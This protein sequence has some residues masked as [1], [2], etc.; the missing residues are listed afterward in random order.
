MPKISPSNKT[1]CELRGL[2]LFHAGWSNCSMRVRMTLEE[3]GLSWTSHHLN[4]RV[5]EHITPAYFGIHPNGLVPTLIDDGDVW[6]ESADIIRYLDETYPGPRLVPDD[7]AGAEMLL[8]WTRLASD[9]HVT[10][11]KT[12]VYSNRSRSHRGKSASDLNLYRKL[13]P[14]KELLEFHSRCSSAEGLTEDD[15]QNAKQVLHA[16]FAELNAH[17]SENRWLAGENFS[18][19]DITWVPL[20]YTLARAGFSFSGYVNVTSWAQAIATRSS[21]NEGV[22]KWFDGPGGVELVSSTEITGKQE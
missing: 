22:V 21:F 11:V 5:G 19:A 2:H 13:Q 7:E 12:Y 17:L 20:H 1:A 10:A 14:D 16:A 3:K 18:L 4:T 9:I 6:I 8:H 15:R